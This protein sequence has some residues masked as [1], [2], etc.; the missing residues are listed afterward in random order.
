MIIIVLIIAK[1]TFACS[2][3]FSS[4]PMQGPT[5]SAA[6]LHLDAMFQ[7]RS[8]G[9]ESPLESSQFSAVVLHPPRGIAWR[10]VKE[11]QQVLEVCECLKDHP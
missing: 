1:V 7:N 6:M 4:I 10:H 2:N 9:K 11:K 3:I 5:S 8:A